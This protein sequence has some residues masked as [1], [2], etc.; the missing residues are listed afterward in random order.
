MFKIASHPGLYTSPLPEPRVYFYYWLSL[1]GMNIIIFHPLNT[2]SMETKIIDLVTDPTT[3]IIAAIA[4]GILGIMLVNRMA[5]IA[6][7]I[8]RSAKVTILK[9][10]DGE[11]K[12]GA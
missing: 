10:E 4:L 9:K 7:K 3:L 8:R 11:Q 2:I 1:S 6:D 5:R 12:D